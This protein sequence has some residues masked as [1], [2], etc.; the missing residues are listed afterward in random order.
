MKS[1]TMVREKL[2]QIRRNAINYGLDHSR[3]IAIETLKW[4]LGENRPEEF[5][6]LKKLKEVEV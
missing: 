5:K 6:K 1:E 3:Y 2:A 4:V